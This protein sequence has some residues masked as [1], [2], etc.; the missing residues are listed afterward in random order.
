LHEIAAQSFSN[1]GDWRD[2]DAF[3]CDPNSELLADFIDDGH[4]SRG[5]GADL[6]TGF[7]RDTRHR[8]ALA[9]EQAESERDGAHVEMLHLGHRDCLQDLGLS[10]FHLSDDFAQDQEDEEQYEECGSD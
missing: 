6:V 5:D 10:V 7:L 9:V 1:E 2:R 8:V 3:V 4:E